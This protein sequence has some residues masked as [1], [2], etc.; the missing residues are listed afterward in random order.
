MTVSRVNWRVVIGVI[1]AA[2][3]WLELFIRY[4][5]YSVVLLVAVGGWWDYMRRR[6]KLKPR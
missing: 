3:V 5:L 4:P 2:A 1:A 6:S